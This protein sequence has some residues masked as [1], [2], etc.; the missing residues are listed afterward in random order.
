MLEQFEEYMQKQMQLSPKTYALY[1]KDIQNFRCFLQAHNRD[2][3]DIRSSDACSYLATLL[4]KQMSYSCGIRIIAALKLFCTYLSEKYGIPDSTRDITNY[5]NNTFAHFPVLCTERHLRSV[6]AN[7]A[8]ATSYADLRDKLIVHLLYFY[9][10]GV[11]YLV[12]LRWQDLSNDLRTLTFM[13]NTGS[14]RIALAEN[15]SQ[16]LSKYR[17]A[18]AGMGF[19]TTAQDY[20][21]SVASG[22]SIQP[23]S[24]QTVWSMLKKLLAKEIQK[25]TNSSL[26]KVDQLGP[27]KGAH[28]QDLFTS[29]SSAESLAKKPKRIKQK[30]Q[31]LIPK[32]LEE[33]DNFIEEQRIYKNKH[34]RA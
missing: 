17:A 29:I 30:P 25:Q 10:L 9:H 13:R 20:L 16:A 15:D 8:C 3:T 12:G 34:P 19:L 7:Y 4:H 26:A 32:P 33:V 24:R 5:Q 11:N 23:L 18:Q 21:F 1:S 27:I 31:A 14:Q 28:K 22:S 6:I 2:I